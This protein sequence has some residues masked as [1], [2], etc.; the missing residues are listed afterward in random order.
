MNAPTY[1]PPA[2]YP[3]KTAPD[4]VPAFVAELPQVRLVR[5]WHP[6][7][8]DTHPNVRATIARYTAR[9]W[10]CTF[11]TFKRDLIVEGARAHEVRRAA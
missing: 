8:Q 7:H 5:I 6:S 1:T 2:L 4:D 10:S 9:G 3:A 11:T